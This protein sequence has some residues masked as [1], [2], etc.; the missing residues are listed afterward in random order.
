MKTQIFKTTTFATAFIL[1]LLFTACQKADNEV[2]PVSPAS[3]LAN[4][5]TNSSEITD[6]ANGNSKVF[7]PSAHP[8]GKS[9]AEWTQEWIREFFNSDCENIPWVNP[10]A[11]LFHT[12]GPVYIMAGIAEIGGSAHVTIPHGKAV[13][14]P[15]V[16]FWA[17]VCEGDLEPGQTVEEYLNGLI[18]WAMPFIDESSLS[19]TIDGNQV[20]DLGAY[21]FTT[22]VFN[23]TGNLEMATCFDPCV[24]GA[25]QPAAGGGYYV[26]LKPL[27]KGQHTIHYTS[28]VPDFGLAQDA[29][30]HITVK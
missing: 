4:D 23:F 14:F 8:Y 9:Y 18:A 15:L 19:L 5:P 26:M 16:N 24:T 30:Y 29:T 25:P 21:G 13:L 6:R 1:A 10:E 28:A 27:S 20:T 22:D 17:D 3:E 7:P 11:V 2:V 12:S